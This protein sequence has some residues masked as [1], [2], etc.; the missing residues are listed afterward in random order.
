MSA[1]IIQKAR[2]PTIVTNCSTTRRTQSTEITTVEWKLTRLLHP[3]SIFP[4]GRAFSC[5]WREQFWRENQAPPSCTWMLYSDH[6]ERGRGRERV[7]Q[8]W[9]TSTNECST[10]ETWRLDKAKLS[11]WTLTS[12]RLVTT[13]LSTLYWRCTQSATRRPAWSK[14]KTLEGSWRNVRGLP[15]LSLRIQQSSSF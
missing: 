6:K 14:I 8:R 3:T 7:R 10:W 1:N 11:R 5:N 13:V 4:L 15:M 2:Q 9:K 12:L